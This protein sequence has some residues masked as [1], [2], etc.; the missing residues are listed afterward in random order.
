[1]LKSIY[2]ASIPLRAYAVLR[3][4]E[5]GSYRRKNAVS[6][7]EAD[8]NTLTSSVEILGRPIAV[9]LIDTPDPLN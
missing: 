3:H 1:M 8:I 6:G 5:F 7:V 4:V 9:R 2:S